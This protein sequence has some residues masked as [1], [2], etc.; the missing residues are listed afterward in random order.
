MQVSCRRAQLRLRFPVRCPTVLPRAK[1]GTKPRT[2]ARW[3]RFPKATRAA[4][5]YVGASYSTPYDPQH[6][7]WNNPDLFLHFVVFEGRL[8]PNVLELKGTRYPQKLVGTRTMGGHRGRLYEQV[9]YALCRCGL[10]GHYTFIW[11]E[12]GTTYAASLHRWLPK[13]TPRVL[14]ALI[15]NLKH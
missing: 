4:W 7:E 8:P 11:H 14:D 10:G 5:A 6:W 13:P 12:N 2:Y 9:S 15:L 3:A 1:D